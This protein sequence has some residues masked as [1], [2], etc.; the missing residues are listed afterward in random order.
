MKSSDVIIG[1]V[2]DGQVHFADRHAEGH[3]LPAKDS[4]QDWSLLSGQENGQYTVLKVARKL[5]TC[6]DQDVPIMPGTTRVIFAYSPNDPA[7]DDTISY[8]GSTRG[9]KSVLLLDPPTS[10]KQ[11]INLPSDVKTLEFTNRNVSVPSTDTTYWCTAWKIPDLGGKHHMIRYEPVIQ[12]GH[13]RLLHHIILYYC[14]GSLGD[15]EP[16]AF[17]CNQNPLKRANHCQHVFVAWAIGGKAFN[18]PSHVG[19]SLGSSGDPGY[20]LMETHYD[21]PSM[22]ADFVD[23]SGLRVYLTRQLR[24]HDGGVLMAG[25]HVDAYQII[26]PYEPSFLSTGYCDTACIAEGLGDNEIHVF[27]NVLHAHLL[28][29]KL[30][31]R[32]FRNGVELPPVQEDNNYDFDYQEARMLESER[33]IKKGDSLMVECE[34][35][36]TQRT[37]V[38][39]GGLSSREEM[40]LSFLIYYPRNQLS[41]CTSRMLYV[42]PDQFSGHS[43]INIVDHRL[44]WTDPKTH[45]GFNHTLATS[46]HAQACLGSQGQ[47]Q[48]YR[49]FCRHTKQY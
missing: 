26:P 6:D 28:G 21:N 9:T 31:T 12:P 4:S 35:D 27:A 18:Y 45:E 25:V 47:L 29:T 7:S 49:L 20:F 8:H 34:Y 19:F 38:T 3:F 1:W 24:Q 37:T 14:E 42:I 41:Q 36:S 2:K 43:A 23:D 32:H 11:T 15:N 17:Q 46:P 48:V 13:E 30:R 39:H 22:R 44:D 16:S 10:D 5:D 33:T 40:C